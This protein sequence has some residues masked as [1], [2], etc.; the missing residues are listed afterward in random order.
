MRC[1]TGTRSLVISFA[2]FFGGYANIYICWGL[3]A[4]SHGSI[5]GPLGVVCF[6][7]RSKSKKVQSCFNIPNITKRKNKKVANNG[8]GT[9]THI[10]NKSYDTN[11]WL[12]SLLEFSLLRGGQD[13][14]QFHGH[15]SVP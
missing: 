2:G 10:S 14:L 3:F 7:N 15:G 8:T 12:S 6:K 9:R 5:K 13:R 11:K 4:D 1:W